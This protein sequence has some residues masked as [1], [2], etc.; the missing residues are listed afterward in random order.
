M[1]TH[2]LCN[3]DK[4]THNHNKKHFAPI[5]ISMTDD[6]KSHVKLISIKLPTEINSTSLSSLCTL[7]STASENEIRAC[8]LIVYVSTPSASAFFIEKYPTA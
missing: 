3:R 2:F 7:I 4:A 6:V 5:S 8:L 1:T